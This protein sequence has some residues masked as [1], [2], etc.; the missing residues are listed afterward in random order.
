MDDTTHPALDRAR[1]KAPRLRRALLRWYRR[2]AR[3]LPWRTR[4]DPW[5]VWV[6][7]I[8]LQPTRVETVIPYFTRFLEA[9]P[10]V[11][12]LAR[13]PEDRVLKLWEGLGY[14]RRVRNLHRAARHVVE[15]RGG[16]LPDTAEG[17]RT[18]PGVGAYTAAAIASI[19]F[20]EPVAVVDGNVKRV[21]ARLFRIDKTLGQAEG[22]KTLRALADRL[23]APRRPGDHNQA[24]MDLGASVC[25]P[26]NPACETCPLRRLCE[27]FAEDEPT[28]YPR[29]R[30]RARP[31]H[32]V[33]TAAVIRRQGRLLLGKR[34]PEGLLGGLWEFPGGKVEAG[35][36]P[37]AALR[38]EL[39]EELGVAARVGTERGS[40]E[41]A[42]THF[43][44]TLKLFEAS[45]GRAK[46]QAR[47]H[48]A[49]K[50][51]LPAQLA[52]HALPTATR[53]ALRLFEAGGAARTG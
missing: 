36:T 20:G 28:A 2:H 51:V 19:A 18:L 25:T 24:V 49:L 47:W 9:F 4:P 44:I 32:R 6:S 21:I 30:P 16:A 14:Y 12:D 41:H 53:K 3:E 35:E 1:R 45:I 43:T 23:L 40:V 31:P 42:Y 37:R 26:K 7:E 10:T 8:M 13:A 29:R 48:T 46:P 39:K 17:W 38:R 52:D 33:V 34:P 5:P 11:E 22:E 27:A 50:W 15:A